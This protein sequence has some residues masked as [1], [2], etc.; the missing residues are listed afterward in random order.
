MAQDTGAMTQYAGALPQHWGHRNM[1]I[2][3]AQF[4]CKR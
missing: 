2:A 3:C 1:L 4:I